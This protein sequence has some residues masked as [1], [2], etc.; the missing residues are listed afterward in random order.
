MH[1]KSFIGT[2]AD[3]SSK[4]EMMDPE[5]VE[6]C[7][8]DIL[9]KI[10]LRYPE[11]VAVAITDGIGPTSMGL[12]GP[13]GGII[14]F[15]FELFAMMN[16]A[17]PVTF[18]DVYDG[19]VGD[20]SA[21]QRTELL[22]GGYL[23]PTKQQIQF[24]FGHEAAHLKHRHTYETSKIA[25]LVALLT[26][27]GLKINNHVGHSVPRWSFM[28]IRNTPLYVGLILSVTASVVFALS[29]DQELQ[30]DATA[31]RKL[32]LKDDALLLKEQQLEQNKAMRRMGAV[33]FDKAGNDWTDLEHPP[34]ML[35]MVNLK[36][37]KNSIKNRE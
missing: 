21:A 33:G 9:R 23:V 7:F 18:E 1:P 17:T 10:G 30:A 35:Q 31:A 2:V 8:G 27:F 11:Q 22:E 4:L 29:W 28:Q 5:D 15:P 16:P 36:W 34:T 14:F 25:V 26:H 37:L 19:P 3:R 6:I 20:I 12:D 24:I 13:R 32:H